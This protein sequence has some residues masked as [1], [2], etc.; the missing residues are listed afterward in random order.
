MGFKLNEA[1][2]KDILC[3][4]EDISDALDYL[5]LHLPEDQLPEQFGAAKSTL[6]L[7][8]NTSTLSSK[9]NLSTDQ[10]LLAKKISST[11]GF[12]LELC[13]A[14]ISQSSDEDENAIVSQIFF[15]ATQTQPSKS[16]LIASSIQQAIDEE[17]MV[18]E[19][20]FAQD[21]VKVTDRLLYVQFPG[22]FFPDVS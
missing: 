12:P 3:N 8:S 10:A 7:V 2:R 14:T 18:L 11:F 15:A 4:C 22:E 13:E 1:I 19:S 21:F 6:K 5:C 9:T 20:I 17:I 16:D